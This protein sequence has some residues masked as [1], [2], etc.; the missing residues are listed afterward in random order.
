MG[1]VPSHEKTRGK[2]WSLSHVRIQQD[3]HLQ[4]RK[5]VLS[6]NQICWHLDLRLPTSRTERNKCLWFKPSR[7][8]YFVTATWTKILLQQIPSQCP[9]SFL[10][11]FIIS[12]LRNKQAAVLLHPKDTKWRR[13]W[14]P[15]PI[16]LPGESHGRRSL[17]GYSPR[18]SQRV[19][20]DWATSL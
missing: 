13:K 20:H 11:S 4:T 7:L 15:T 19:R 5:R 16:S 12:P 6:R 9:S 18:G 2:F 14:Q 8:W 17:V 3:S 1:L 10:P